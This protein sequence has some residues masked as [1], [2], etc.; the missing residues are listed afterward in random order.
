MNAGMQ[1][2]ARGAPCS[3]ATQASRNAVMRPAFI[4]SLRVGLAAGV[5]FGGQLA[6]SQAI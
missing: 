4:L 3:F 2:K 1:D 6:D 5:C